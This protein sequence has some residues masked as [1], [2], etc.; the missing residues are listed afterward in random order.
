[1]P[2]EIRVPP[3]GESLV[4][5]VEKGTPG[6]SFGA[7]EKKLGWKSQPTAMVLFESELQ[8][9]GARHTPLLT[10][11]LGQPGPRVLVDLVG[12]QPMLLGHQVGDRPADVRVAH[13]RES[14]PTLR[15]VCK[16]RTLGGRTH[17]RRVHHPRRRRRD[18][19]KAGQG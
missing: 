7:Q 6:L 16:E 4:D 2:A 3:L 18:P 5:A 14:S 1:M 11:P 12:P 8:Q 17:G 10:A 9:G 13:G 15:G 19:Q